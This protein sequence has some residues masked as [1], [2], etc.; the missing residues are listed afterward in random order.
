MK[1]VFYD[2]TCPFCVRI[3]NQFKQLDKKDQYTFSSLDGK[4]AK[5]LFAG[6]YGFLR[7]K[8]SIVFLEGKRVWVR[9]NAVLRLLWL[10]GKGKWRYLGA[11]FVIPGFL[12][13]PF[14]RVG[15]IL[16]KR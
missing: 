2:D 13:N 8:R 7:K 3:V 14:Y 15:S 16:I 12:I 4:K 6:N 10:L 5:T 1:R 11:L 9:A